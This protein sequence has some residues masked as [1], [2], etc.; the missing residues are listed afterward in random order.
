MWTKVSSASARKVWSSASRSIS[1][2]RP[3]RSSRQQLPNPGRPLVR[4]EDELAPAAPADVLVE[5]RDA[6]LLEEPQREARRSP[7]RGGGPAPAPP[8]TLAPAEHLRDERAARDAPARTT[9]STSCGTATVPK[10]GERSRSTWSGSRKWFMPPTFAHR[11][12]EADRD[13]RAE[14]GGDRRRRARPRRAAPRAGRPAAAI[15][16]RRGRARRVGPAAG[17]VTSGPRGR[18]ALARPC[19]QVQ[20]DA[21]VRRRGGRR[22]PGRPRRAPGL[23]PSSRKMAMTPGDVVAD[24]QR[25]ARR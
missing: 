4:E 25:D 8:M 19:A 22:A 23:C 15:A 1:E 20:R 18:R 2:S 14:H 10:R 17:R 9:A 5:H 16:R 11:V 6:R 13:A 24:P 12:V 21:G 7:R 3:C